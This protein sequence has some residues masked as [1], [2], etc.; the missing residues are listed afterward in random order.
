MYII[1]SNVGDRQQPCLTPLPHNSFVKFVIIVIIFQTDSILAYTSDPVTVNLIKNLFELPSGS[2]VTT[3][4]LQ[5]LARVA[6][7]CITRDKLPLLNIWIHIVEVCYY[8]INHLNLQSYLITLVLEL[9][10]ILFFTLENLK[11]V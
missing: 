9:I 11:L 8:F 7:E 1:F 10:N 3:R 6:Y 5:Y 2:I 4:H